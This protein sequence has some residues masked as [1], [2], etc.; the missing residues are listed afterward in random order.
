MIRA[1][2]WSADKNPRMQQS[3]DFKIYPRSTWVLNLLGLVAASAII[4]LTV[5]THPRGFF[6]HVAPITCA[7]YLVITLLT[8]VRPPG[9]VAQGDRLILR[10]FGR[11]RSIPRKELRQVIVRPMRRVI[12]GES[13]SQN[14]HIFLVVG[15]DSANESVLPLVW[16]DVWLGR[17]NAQ[18]A[19]QA[20]QLL[21]AWMEPNARQPG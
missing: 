16:C 1:Q 3:A 8:V 12:G 18:E 14:R 15:R 7:I 17:L 10:R 21:T 13:R 4:V 11:S 5:V 9:V 2:R 19:A 20:N 6:W